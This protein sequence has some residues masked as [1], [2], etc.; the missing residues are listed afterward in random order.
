MRD[1]TESNDS[2]S[3][4]PESSSPHAVRYQLH[5][6]DANCAARLGTLTTPRGEVPLPTFMPVGTVGTV[7][8]LVIDQVAATGA[9]IILGNT[10]HLALRPGAEVVSQL[11][12]LHAFSGW[13]GPILTDSGGFQVFSLA[14][15]VKI[16][17]QGAQFQSHI[18][19]ARLSLTP[20][21]SI[22]IQEQ[23]GSDIAMQLD[24]VI[25]LPAERPA[26]AD[27]MLR[28]VRWAERCQQAARREDQSIF[29]IV[30]G[31]LDPELR[32]ESAERLV[33]LDFAGY[34]I[35][36]LSVGEPPAEMYS[37]IE[38]TTPHL[39]VDRPRYLMGVGKPED[40]IEAVYRGV[41][42]FDCVMP[43]RNGRNAL[44]FTDEGP[45]RLRNECHKVD[46]RP[47]EEDCPCPA[48]RHSRGYLRHLF[49][50]GEMLGPVLLSIHNLT[51]YQRLMA[52]AREAIA[53]DRYAEYRQQ[54]LAGWQ[55][56]G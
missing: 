18:D 20:E 33:E 6:T 35:G 28:S 51:Y 16:T 11:G 30:Q 39:P 14:E 25:A 15:R 49:M 48:C 46:P 8:G 52:G 31:G 45:V 43:T 7:K 40:L 50:A 24:H 12:G 4:R 29:A 9:G 56:G 10:Y 55:S 23:L 47:L 42:M 27:A 2:A 19:G 3:P 32:Q 34:A 13:S 37:T 26:I 17:E 21:E 22:A 1:E 44:A 54:K 41:D 5:H 38:V 53:A 36:G